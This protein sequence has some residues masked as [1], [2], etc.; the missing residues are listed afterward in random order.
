MG[1]IT[2]CSGETTALDELNRCLGRG[3]TDAGKGGGST[4]KRGHGL[5]LVARETERGHSVVVRLKQ[6]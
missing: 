1:K 2:R 6:L 4:S 5:R 3:K